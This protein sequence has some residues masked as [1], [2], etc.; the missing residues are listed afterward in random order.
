MHLHP[1]TQSTI[2]GLILFPSAGC[3]P[4]AGGAGTSEHVSSF[5]AILH[6]AITQSTYTWLSP[7]HW[8][9]CC[10]GLGLEPPNPGLLPGPPD[11][12]PGPNPGCG[13]FF[14]CSSD[15]SSSPSHCRMGTH[16]PSWFLAKP[17]LHLHPSTHGTNSLTR[18]TPHSISAVISVHWR[19]SSNSVHVM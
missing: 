4:L 15:C 18:S 11:L 2:S 7:W 19:L 10:C 14:C 5:G 13:R 9:S 6:G 8:S 1:S 17:G 3:W 16:T 12:P